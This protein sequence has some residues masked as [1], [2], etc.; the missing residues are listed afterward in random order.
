MISSSPMFLPHSNG[1]GSGFGELTTSPG[2]SR[3]WCLWIH[4]SSHKVSVVRVDL[5]RA[6]CRISRPCNWSLFGPC[7][8]NLQSAGTICAPYA[9]AF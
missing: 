1:T 4:N 2:G 8:C 3:M 6:P 9:A 7:N 5:C